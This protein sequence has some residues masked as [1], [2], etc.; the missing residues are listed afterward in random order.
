MLDPTNTSLGASDNDTQSSQRIALGIEYDGAAFHGWQRQGDPA[1]STVQGA[2]EKAL[3]GV[4]AHP[5][6][7]VCAGR[8]DTGV[9]ATGQVVHLECQVDRGEKAWLRGTNSL[10]PST[11]RVR[12]AQTVGQDFHARFSALSRRYHY[13]IC[14]S[15]VEPA[16]MTRQLTHTRLQLDITAMHE[17]GQFL[18]GEND[19]SAFRAAGCQSRTPFRN[20][21]HLQVIR[22]HRYIVLDI[23]A[24][25]FLQ[26]MVRN[27][28]GSLIE[29]GAGRQPA[30]WVREVLHSK[31][32][33][34]AAV[35]ASPSGLYLVAVRYPDL[36]GLPIEAVGPGFLQPFA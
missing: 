32:R 7:L 6:S 30:E 35:T 21:M 12:W 3:A 11:V 36:F 20:V 9:H 34:L 10:L 5:I 24:N 19:F 26:H 2:L 17:A 25:A 15:P 22:H 4:A 28:A 18:L 1:L 27:I 14:D 23:E 29:V 33:K 13:V 16:I 8:T 31:D